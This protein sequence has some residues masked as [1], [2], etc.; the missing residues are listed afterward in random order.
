MCKVEARYS[1]QIC[2][3]NGVVI[4]TV[5]GKSDSFVKNFLLLLQAGFSGSTVQVVDISGE[6]RDTSGFSSGYSA[7]EVGYPT[8]TIGIGSGTSPVGI[9]DFKLESTYTE[10]QVQFNAIAESISP[11]ITPMTPGDGYIHCDICRRRFIN[12]SQSEVYFSELGLYVVSGGYDFLILRDVIAPIAIPSMGGYASI[13][14]TLMTE[15]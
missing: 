1:V 3:A 15:V 2:S 4:D 12:N 9:S 8:R 5:S 13:A 7:T 14:Y 11:M 10:S 6:T